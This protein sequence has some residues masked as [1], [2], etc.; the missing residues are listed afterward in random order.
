MSRTVEGPEAISYLVSHTFYRELATITERRGYIDV[1]NAGRYGES[2]QDS[3][4]MDLLWTVL[5]YHPTKNSLKGLGYT[6]GEAI[7]GLYSAEIGEIEIGNRTAEAIMSFTI[8]TDLYDSES[9]GSHFEF[10]W[11]V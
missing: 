5:N 10:T 8:H 4:Y 7:E 2:E 11:E 3:D 6:I 1:D 9:R